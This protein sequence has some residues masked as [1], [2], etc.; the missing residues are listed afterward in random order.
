MLYHKC[1]WLLWR[2]SEI[3][4]Q[5]NV[6]DNKNK[7]NKDWLVR[8][9]VKNFFPWTACITYFRPLF[10][11][12]RVLLNEFANIKPNPLASSFAINSSWCKQSKSL[13]RSLTRAQNALPLS[14]LPFH[15]SIML[16]KQNCVLNPLR[17][18]HWHLGK[19]SSK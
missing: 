4:S 16:T 7:R 3:K 18:P 10:S 9:T 5:K 2:H 15:F 1:N 11:I 8:N 12:W 17:N 13:E 14:K 6:K 19:I